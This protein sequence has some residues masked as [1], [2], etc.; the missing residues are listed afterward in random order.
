MDHSEA[1]IALV[2][3]YFD[4]ELN[5]AELKNFTTRLESD[6][7]F[8]LLVEQ[9]KALIAAIRFDG[10]ASN[11]QY[12]EE[13]ET[14]LQKETP[15]RISSGSNKWYYYAAAAA[16]G[17]TIL[18]TVFMNSFNENPDQLFQAYF[19]PYPNM[20]EPT[21]RSNQSSDSKRAEAFQAYE[22]GNYQKAAT[23]FTDLL[24]DNKDAGML[25]LLGNSN[26]MLGNLEEAKANFITLNDDFDDLD[27]QAKWYLSLCYLKNGEMDKAQALLK[28]LGDT[29]ISYATKAK[30][31]LEKVN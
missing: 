22:Q 4:A 14:K 15:L 2:E 27:M 13:L 17:M 10:A 31:L 8:K 30:E 18:V 5:D 6:E 21:V 28:E 1:D 29:E 11:L 9:E 16:V 25:L 19:T 7:H 24:K 23:L 3:K 20:F 12:L 26:M